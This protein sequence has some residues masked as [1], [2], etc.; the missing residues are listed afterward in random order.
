MVVVTG[1]SGH[2]GNVLVR[3]LLAQGDEVR[4]LIHHTEGA[5]P[6]DGLDIEMVQGD[7]CNPDSLIKAFEGSDIVY[8]LAG[9]ISIMPGED[10]LLRQVNVNGTRNVVEA[11]LKTGVRRLVY[12]SSIHAIQEPTQDISID[13]SCP[14]NPEGVPRGY[15]RSKANA[16]LVVL[17]GVKRGLDAVIVHPTGVTGPYDYRISQLGRLVIDCINGN[18]KAYVDGA[19][20]FVDVRDVA[21]GV[22]L[23]GEKGRCGERYILSGE[24]VTVRRLLSMIEGISGVKAPPIKIPFW[25]AKLA[26]HFTPLYHRLTGSQPLFTSYSMDVLRSNSLVSSE[27]ARRELGYSPRPVKESI[28]D[29]FNWFI[30][31]GYIRTISAA[32]PVKPS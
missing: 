3:Q 16:T 20:D 22:I 1:A 10:K 2:I 29:A 17:D 23:A 8:H 6:L 25:L 31:N 14:C 4:A 7:V 26:S 21:N 9:V 18:L 15:G 27:K 32:Q 11:C 13:E 19:Y 30:D 5:S 12:T 24:Q 28:A